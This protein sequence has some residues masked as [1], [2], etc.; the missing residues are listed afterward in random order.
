MLYCVFVEQLY[1]TSTVL[2]VLQSLYYDHVYTCTWWKTKKADAN[3]PV[4]LLFSPL[5]LSFRNKESIYN[6]FSKYKGCMFVPF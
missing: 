5:I 6:S 1:T 2:L 3:Q 4:Q